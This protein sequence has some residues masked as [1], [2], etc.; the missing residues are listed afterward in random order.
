MN[1]LPLGTPLHFF[2]D[3]YYSGPGGNGGTGNGPYE[4][5]MQ[6]ITVGGGPTPPA[7][8]APV[9]MNGD[10]KSDY[11]VVRSAGGQS[12]QITW[13]TMFSANAPIPAPPEEQALTAPSDGAPTT[14]T[15]WGV[16]D[17]FFVP[18]DYDGDGK[19]DFAVW[20]PGPNA[21]FYIVRSATA[22]MY[23]EQFGQTGDDP[24]VVGDYTGDN[25]DDIAVYRDGTNPGDQ[26]TWFYRSIG[27]PPGVQ[28]IPWGQSGDTPAPGDYDGDSKYD[29]VIQRPDSNGVNGRFWVREAD[30][31]QYS[32]WFGLAN[33]SVVPG[34]YDDDGKTD[35][36]VARN[37]N[38]TIRW[39]FEPSGTAGVTVVTDTWGVTATDTIAQAD[40]DGDGKTEYVV[41]RPGSPGV[42][43]VM[44]P[45]TRRIWTQPWGM[46]GDI[47]VANYN[48]H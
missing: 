42:F 13:W 6:D 5:R 24:T 1:S 17:D 32:Q 18:A 29:F 46:T 2:V 37:D 19:D 45:V 23:T 12:G 33:D 38:G 25:R 40:H 14:P 31:L 30:G 8:D 22:T 21:V 48:E 35:F 15:N 47:A 10:G 16:S 41:W 28:S 36:A 39:D 11:V 3:S 34:D 43:Y 26:S 7:N 9:D 44:T 20:R 27:S 4:V